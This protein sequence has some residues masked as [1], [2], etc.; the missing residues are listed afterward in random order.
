MVYNGGHQSG[1]MAKAI[2]LA[3]EMVRA[4]AGFHADQ[5]WRHIR[6]SGLNLTTRSFLPQNNRAPLVE[7]NDVEEVLADIDADH[8]ADQF[9]CWT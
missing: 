1:V 2:E 3:A 8:R 6:K 9:F 5:A 7:A 4:N